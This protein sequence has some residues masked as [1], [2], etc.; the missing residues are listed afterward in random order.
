MSIN[1]IGNCQWQCDQ[2]GEVMPDSNLK[3]W[4]HVC[5]PK[6]GESDEHS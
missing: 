4:D 3:Q 1:W 5:K 2:C 6:Q